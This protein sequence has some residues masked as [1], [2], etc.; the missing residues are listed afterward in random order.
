[1]RA[2]KSDWIE[3][4]VVKGRPRVSPKG[5]LARELQGD[6]LS[7]FGCEC[8]VEHALEPTDIC[9]CFSQEDSYQYFCWFSVSELKEICTEFVDVVV[10]VESTPT[11]IQCDAGPCH[12]IVKFSG[13]VSSGRIRLVRNALLAL[14][15][16][17]RL[18]EFSDT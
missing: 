1:V 8:L 10:E 12:N 11:T 6:G 3:S 13:N 7:C 5:F 4:S 9:R 14:I 18:V 2:L 16:D 17:E 15:T